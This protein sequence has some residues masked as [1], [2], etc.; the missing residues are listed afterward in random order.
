[1]QCWATRHYAEPT[2]TGRKVRLDYCREMPAAGAKCAG[3]HYLLAGLSTAR[4]SPGWIK[5]HPSALAGSQQQRVKA[6][7]ELAFC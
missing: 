7:P 1:M 3:R 6:N 4:K 2:A 5:A